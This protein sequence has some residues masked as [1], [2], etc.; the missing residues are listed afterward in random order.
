[1]KNNNYY[2]SY[3][4]KKSNKYTKL[5]YH[6]SI[7]INGLN[8]SVKVGVV[9][10]PLEMFALVAAKKVWLADRVYMDLLDIV[11]S[12]Y[13]DFYLVH[14]MPYHNAVVNNTIKKQRQELD[15]V[16]RTKLKGKTIGSVTM[17]YKGKERTYISL[18]NGF[19]DKVSNSK[20]NYSFVKKGPSYTI[21]K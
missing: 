13:N 10:Y 21:S 7:D 16:V 11:W 20:K 1:M 3:K 8:C 12:T 6:D 9:L 5:G 19:V 17:Q 14:R 4:Y 2:N 18:G 15:H